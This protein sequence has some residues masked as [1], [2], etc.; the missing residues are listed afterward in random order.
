LDVRAASPELERLWK[1]SLA[2]PDSR[3]ARNPFRRLAEA[4]RDYGLGGRSRPLAGHKGYSIV[5]GD[6]GKRVVAIVE[7]STGKA[8]GGL[9][10]GNLFVSPFHRGR[11]FGSEIVI[12]AFE[13]GVMHPD[14]MRLDMMT[15]STAGRANRRSAH[16]K[17]VERALESGV[18]VPEAILADYPEMVSPA[19]GM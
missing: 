6:V 3:S 10:E 12:L 17:A 8:V 2:N 13:T 11:G 4:V 18:A 1:K 9:M 14:R 7:D 16:R 5:A 19:P 15:L